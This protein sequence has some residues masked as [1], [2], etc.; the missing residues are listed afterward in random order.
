MSG[1]NLDGDEMAI[2][3]TIFYLCLLPFS[4]PPPMSNFD[5]IVKESN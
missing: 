3:K 2:K 1:N 5:A 4:G